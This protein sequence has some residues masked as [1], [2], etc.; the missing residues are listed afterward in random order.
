MSL[1]ADRDEAI[2]ETRRRINDRKAARLR[3][4]KMREAAAQFAEAAATIGSQGNPNL[5]PAQENTSMQTLALTSMALSLA[6]NGLYPLHPPTV[7]G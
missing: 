3:A 6:A 4:E 5:T 2:E 7:V 1:Q